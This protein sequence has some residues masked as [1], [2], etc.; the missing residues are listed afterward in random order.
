LY[1][2]IGFR[3]C[4]RL[5]RI[6]VF[7]RIDLPFFVEHAARVWIRHSTED[8]SLMRRACRPGAMLHS[9][10]RE[11]HFFPRGYTVDA[12]EFE[13]DCVSDLL[14]LACNAQ[15]VSIPSFITS[16]ESAS[17][18]G[19]ESV[20][21]VEI[22]ASIEQLGGFYEFR[23]LQTIRFTAV[24][25]LRVVKGFEGC[26]RLERIEIPSSVEIIDVT[27]FS[28]CALTDV[29]FSTPSRLDT[30]SGFPE[31]PR[32]Q[33]ITIPSS[34]TNISGFNRCES[35]NTIG[36]EHFPAPSVFFTPDTCLKVLSGFSQCN[37]LVAV[38]IPASVTR[39]NKDAFSNYRLLCEWI[40]S[41][42]PPF[43]KSKGFQGVP[44]LGELNF[45]DRFVGSRVFI[46]AID[47][48]WLL[49]L[50]E[51]NWRFWMNSCTSQ[52]V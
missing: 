21:E 16:V 11:V 9:A 47:S 19:D 40:F 50:Q 2:N 36:I 48:A 34:V 52:Q 8:W 12:D 37:D 14:L 51:V 23:A 15:A 43:P 22:P 39:I 1:C 17:L 6:S 28:S 49:F 24:G 10:L 44:Y 38:E 45:R 26:R 35:L 30:I 13:I 32:L 3:W 46:T 18:L 5:S 25:R 4:D 29:A 41:D 7:E 31:C 42:T 20:S 27:A 33:S